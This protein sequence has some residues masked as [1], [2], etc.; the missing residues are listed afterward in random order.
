MPFVPPARTLGGRDCSIRLPTFP[1]YSI[2]QNYVSVRRFFFGMSIYRETHV[3]SRDCVDSIVTRLNVASWIV[4]RFPSRGSGV[5]RGGLGGFK[6]LLL[7][8]RRYNSVWVLVRSTIFFHKS[9]SSTLLFQF[10]IF[11]VCRSFLTSSFHL[12]FRLPI[13]REANGFHL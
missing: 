6:P 7:L 8:N 12:F 10:L 4:D 11:I 9:L 13:G 2:S 3:D 1:D 5:P